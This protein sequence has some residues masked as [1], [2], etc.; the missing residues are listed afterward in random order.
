MLD[1]IA[2]QNDNNI[3]LEKT[4]DHLQYIPL[5]ERHI[6]RAKFIHIIRNGPDTIASLYEVT[7]QYPQHW[8]NKNWS[9]DACTEKWKEAIKISF[10][11]RYKTNHIIVS[12]EQL[13]NNPT[14]SIERIFAILGIHCV[15]EILSEYSRGGGDL[16][17]DY[18]AWKKPI[19]TISKLKHKLKFTKVFSEEEQQYISEKIDFQNND[20]DAYLRDLFNQETLANQSS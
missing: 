6:K 4:P 18:E 13:T 20:I 3:W 12:Y 17:Y 10:N 11:Y 5:I 16:I 9:I 8:G 1:R 15:P 2:Q 19:Q 14:E 7:R